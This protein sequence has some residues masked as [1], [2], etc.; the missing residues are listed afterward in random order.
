VLKA[1]GAL[2]S[3]GILGKLFGVG[4][5]LLLAALFGTTAPV[6]AY[7]IAQTATLIPVNFFTSD[8]LNAGFIPLYTRYIKED[9][10]K[11]Q[12][13]FWELVIVL[14][15]LTFLITGFLF[16][17]SRL[18]VSILA[19]GFDF[20][21]I[22]M[23]VNFLNV[24]ALG[25]PFYVL[26]ALFSYLEMGNGGYKLPALRASVQNLGL[27]MGTL[28][29]FWLKEPVFL[30]W[31][32]TGAY[33]IFSFWGAIMLSRRG[34]LSF[35]TKWSWYEAKSLL[36]NFWQIIRPLILLPFMLQGNIAIERA[37]ASLMGIGVVAALDY[38]KLLSDTG[39]AL[40]AVPLGLAGLSS[41][42]GLT[43]EKVVEQLEKI[44]PIL[45]IF[46]VPFSGFIAIHSEQVVQLLYARGA[47]DFESVNLTKKILFGLAL[48]LWAQVA[49]YM[50]MKALNA[51]FR[52]REV[53]KFM[54]I[55]LG[56]NACTNLLLY[57][58]LGPF[59]LGLG[60][61]IY[62]LMLFIL[63][64]KALNLVNVLVPHMFWLGLGTVFY[65]PIAKLFHV[66]GWIGMGVDG[67]IFVMFW[68]VYILAVPKLRV[69]VLYTWKKTLHQ[70]FKTN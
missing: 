70:K 13:L 14:M 62:G 8:S 16:I 48:G 15:V 68:S 40:L 44:I 59:T 54:G 53:V 7:R 37:V 56:L 5:E 32:F 9:R 47:F 12:L 64:I 28:L 69:V 58:L 21:S 4:R 42:S 46:T 26:G 24:M 51:Q 35:P 6:G 23:A 49:G 20:H 66:N 10:S 19:P 30:A 38:A 43:P 17:S 50:L 63:T 57:R 52:N 11:A 18:W 34:Y 41:L 22:D 29:A 31:G 25:V 3:G 36:N 1:A 55:A 33:I 27:I 61:S 2:I 67:L 39:V 60:A 45:L 65:I